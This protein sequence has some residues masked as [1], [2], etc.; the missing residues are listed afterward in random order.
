MV[1]PAP[2]PTST[3]SLLFM[4][5]GQA[6]APYLRPSTGRSYNVITVVSFPFTVG[7]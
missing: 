5:K 1:L 2:V 4:T 3:C 7:L 6:R